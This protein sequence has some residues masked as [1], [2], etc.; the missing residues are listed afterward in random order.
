MAFLP[1]I[2]ASSR[3]EPSGLWNKP[4]AVL[5]RR[6][7]EAMNQSVEPLLEKYV[8][9]NGEILYPLKV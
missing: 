9:P 3:G 7:I 2:K 6:L 4:G 1:H 5:E 8:R